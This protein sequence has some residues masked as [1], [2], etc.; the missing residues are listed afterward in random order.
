[1]KGKQLDPIDIFKLL[2]RSDCHLCGEEKCINFAFKLADREISLKDC[3][4]INECENRIKYDRLYELTKPAIRSVKVGKGSKSVTIGG[5]HVLYRHEDRYM[6]PTA[7]VV[8][9][10]DEMAEDEFKKRI[11][12][13][14]NFSYNYIG[15]DQTLDMIAVRSTSN[16]PTKFS[17]SVKEA[18]KLTDKPLMLCS[19]D[20]EVM[21]EGLEIAGQ[22]KP[23]IYAATVN[24]W[25]KMAD[26]ALLYNS[27]LVAS[28]PFD[29]NS[30]KS[31]T[32]KLLNYGVKD[33]V[34]DP[35]TMIGEGFGKTLENFTILR[36][37]AIVEGDEDLGFP[38]L[39]I[40]LV[41]W[42]RNF[43]DPVVK[44]WN[45]SV[46][47]S[48]LIVR[49][50]D[51]LLIHG[52]K[53]WSLL[54]L[55]ILRQNIY[56]DPKKPISV[57]PELV[58][59]GDPD[60]MS[61]VLLTTNFALTYYT[62]VSDLESAEIDCYLLVVDT[63][64]LSVE[65]AIAGRHLTADLISE[66]LEKFNVADRVK[67]KNLVIPGRAARISREI[68]NKIDWCVSVGPLDSSELPRYLNDRWN[69]NKGS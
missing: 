46:I 13:V 19:K 35:G 53:G 60:E 4:P 8:D 29:L 65:S 63:E 61:P 6:N 17:L 26:L 21:K 22:K 54:P 27:P 7:L 42:G 31:T 25:E 64:G 62:V 14:N 57:K 5:K 47:A 51:I 37:D 40:P 32:I 11:E 68:K 12:V 36:W 15:M 52:I 9:L 59:I 28:A 43:H 10:T 30:L 39:G 67:H 69:P 50:A 3:P 56:T 20:P 45:E 2:P 58:K 38:L 48:S 66:S 49:F 1:M 55:L 18:L 23:L 34:L 24:N 41:V 33:L 44:Q 16:D